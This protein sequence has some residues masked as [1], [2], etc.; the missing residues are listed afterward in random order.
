MARDGWASRLARAWEASQLFERETEIS[1]VDGAL[2]QAL[3]G[4]GGVLALEGAAGLGKSALLRATLARADQ[5]GMV[6]LSARGGELERDFPNG[7]VRQLFERP[8]ATRRAPPS[9]IWWRS[10]R[11]LRPARRAAEALGLAEAVEAPLPEGSDPAFAV[12]HGLYWLVVN[13]SASE[14]GGHR[15]RRRPLGRRAVAALPRPT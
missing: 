13:L 10:R 9:A 7:I 3:S 14:A 12:L 4:L 5:R 11:R 8:L 1:T 6:V 15:D 2:G